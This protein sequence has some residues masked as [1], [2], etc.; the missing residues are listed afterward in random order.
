MF[1]E[2][3]PR[4]DIGFFQ[5]TAKEKS[6]VTGTDVVSGQVPIV[7]PT[8]ALRYFL[9]DIEHETGSSSSVLIIG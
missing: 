3:W 1:K 2:L 9:L 6:K 7:K 4:E 5:T 8:L